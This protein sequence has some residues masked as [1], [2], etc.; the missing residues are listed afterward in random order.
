MALAHNKSWTHLVVNAPHVRER[1]DAMSVSLCVFL[2]ARVC[3]S[4]C[5]SV[6]EH[7]SWTTGPISPIF[8]AC[9][10]WSWLDGSSLAALRYVIYFRFCVWRQLI[11]QWALCR[12]RCSDA[13]AAFRH[14]RANAAPTP[15]AWQL[16]DSVTHDAIC[17]TTKQIRRAQGD[18]DGGAVNKSK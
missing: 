5:L 1:S 11:P 14:Q 15:A 10:L 8:S 9:Y 4:V 16:I 18:D 12:Y 17:H 7:V 2:C 3:L 6:C 13:T